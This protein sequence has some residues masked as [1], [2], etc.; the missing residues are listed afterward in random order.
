MNFFAVL[1]HWLHL[2][3][4]IFWVGGNAYQVFVLMPFMSPDN[5]SNE[6]VLKISKRF[7]RMSLLFLVI[8]VITGGINFGFRRVGHE[9][10][11][12]GY[13]SALA[14]KVFLI[15]GMAALLLFGLIRPLDEDSPSTAPGFV[16]SKISLVIGV[17]VIFLAA[18]LRQWQF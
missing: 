13:V 15:V 1:N 8:L 2:I 10:V 4:V 3:S 11:P 14:V 7:T 18:M 17:I 16:Y 5:P 12:S 6:T 9:V